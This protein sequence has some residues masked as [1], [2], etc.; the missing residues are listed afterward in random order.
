MAKV[1]LVLVLVHCLAAKMADY[2]RKMNAE[3]YWAERGL[4]LHLFPSHHSIDLVL[5]PVLVPVLAL[6][7]VLCQI[8]GLLHDHGLL[9]LYRGHLCHHPTVFWALV[10]IWLVVVAAHAGWLAWPKV[11]KDPPY[12]CS[13]HFPR[14]H[15]S[16]PFRMGSV[17]ALATQVLQQS[18]PVDVLFDPFPLDVDA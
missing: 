9:G 1:V 15:N 13:C 7:L 8:H 10:Q 12:Q 4:L 3:S 6:V 14:R 2:W 5:V 18:H 16:V 17:H 11:C